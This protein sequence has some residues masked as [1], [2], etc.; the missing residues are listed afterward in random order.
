MCE[1]Y[2]LRKTLLSPHNGNIYLYGPY[3]NSCRWRRHLFQVLWEANEQF[4]AHICTITRS[5]FHVRD[6]FWWRMECGRVM[7]LERPVNSLEGKVVRG[8]SV[9]TGVI[10]E[11]L[12]GQVM[13]LDFRLDTG[14]RVGTGNKISPAQE[15][16]VTTGTHPSLTGSGG[17]LWSL[18]HSNPCP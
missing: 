8:R 6:F 5:Y 3:Q 15:G 13:W 18:D 16:P 2:Y 7:A 1:S 14:A 12:G 17:P 4:Q 9:R 10:W 11:M